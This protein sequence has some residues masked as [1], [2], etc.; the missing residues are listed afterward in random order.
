[1]KRGDVVW[2]CYDGKMGRGVPGIVVKTKQKAVLVHFKPWVSDDPNKILE[3]WFRRRAW[4]FPPRMW[5]NSN[6]RRRLSGARYKYSAWAHEDDTMEVLIGC[7]GSYYSLRT[8]KQM[9]IHGCELP[10]SDE[11]IA[12]VLAELCA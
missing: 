11:N 12:A 9:R 10:M 5:A 1:M 7:S 3:V 6:N 4:V 2:P 8:E